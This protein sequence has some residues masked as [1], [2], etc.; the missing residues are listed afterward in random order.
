MLSLNSQG[1]LCPRAEG[2]G[3]VSTACANCLKMWLFDRRD[4]EKLGFGSGGAAVE[5]EV[6]T[7]SRASRCPGLKEHIKDMVPAPQTGMDPAQP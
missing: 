2:C 6:S 1:R 3:N 4:E 5:L 7:A